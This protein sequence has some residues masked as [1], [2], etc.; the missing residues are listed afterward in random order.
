[1]A[2]KPVPFVIDFDC[3]LNLKYVKWNQHW[4]QWLQIPMNSHL[5]NEYEDG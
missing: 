1:M 3:V 5:M 2:T 4:A